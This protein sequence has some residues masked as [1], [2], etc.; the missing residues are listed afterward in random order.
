MKPIPVTLVIAGALLLIAL[1]NF[2]PVLT[3]SAAVAAFNDGNIESVLSPSSK[4]PDILVRA[5][6]NQFFFGQGTGAIPLST[7]SIL[8]IILGPAGYRRSG[9]VLAIWVA[10]LAAFWTARQFERSRGAAW[11]SALITMLCGWS[12]TFPLAGL[13]TRTFSLSWS[14]ISIGMIYS[15]QQK[16]SPLRYLI[17]GGFL[18]MAISDTPDVGILFALACGAFFG[19]THFV[20]KDIAHTDVILR[21][22][23][24]L[25]LFVGASFLLS[26]QTVSSMFKTNI[27]GVTQGAQQTAEARYEW[28]TQWSLPKAETWSLIAPDMHGAS[29]RSQTSPYWGAMGRSAGWEQTHQGYR[30]FRLAGYAVGSVAAV[31]FLLILPQLF[32]PR[33]PR[34]L[35]DE[36]T[37]LLRIFCG[38]AFLSL[39][40]SWGKH[41][42]LYRLFHELPFMSTIRNPDK[43]LGP[44]MLFLAPVLAFAVDYLL[45]LRNPVQQAKKS[46]PLAPVVAPAAAIPVVALFS[47]LSFLS[48]KAA[49][50][51]RLRTEGH[52]D[53]VGK[54]F[55]NIL[56]ANLT[57]LLVSTL[58]LAAVIAYLSLRKNTGWLRSGWITLISMLVLFE[59]GM[60]NR[61]YVMKHYYRHLLRPNPLTDFL[62]EVQGTG[63]AKLIPEQNP[64]L[65]NWRFA[66]LKTTGFDLFDPI[67]VSRM[68]TDLQTLID[69]LGNR[70]DR[71]WQLGSV[72]YFITFAKVVPHLD[73]MFPGALRERLRFGLTQ[74]QDTVLPASNMPP[75]QQN[76]RVL[77]YT[78]ALPLYHL[79]PAWTG[80]PETKEGTEALLD[81]LGADSFDPRKETLVFGGTRE[82][83]GR[84]TVSVLRTSSVE[85]VAQIELDAP[86]LLLRNVQYHPDWR[87]WIDDRP[88][89]ILRANWLFQGLE[90]PAGT[91]EIRFSFQPDQTPLLLAAG[92][93]IALLV[94]LP[95]TF[96]RKRK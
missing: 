87:A 77:E 45:K 63:Y 39:A 14:L 34:R 8:E 73:R 74:V 24:M 70:Q 11:I 6:N 59:L 31:L 67:S 27:Q 21:R 91:H 58:A 88:A 20:R 42:P 33:T 32:R 89:E 43:W 75:R 38:L 85:A 57:A 49:F 72:R 82:T 69:T 10:G 1:L 92:S 13:P 53:A 68:P 95:L 84:G 60:A 23:V 9:V 71:L 80:F 18:G 25:V 55:A 50:L 83:G 86:G 96:F 3:D 61:P 79:A 54:I 78:D 35:T 93:R 48:G 94:L 90:I 62:K 37:V 51:S 16:N 26:W 76:M 36:E 17:A 15:A 19:L 41:F 2:L 29:S 5:W 22:V 46:V 28:A 4:Y 81:R 64:L 44:F 30:N 12:Y 56:S 47:I 65:N 52:G 40:L 7:Q 66:M